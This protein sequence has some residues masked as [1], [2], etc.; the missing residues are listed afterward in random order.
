MAF[1]SSYMLSYL[2]K[3]LTGNT[4]GSVPLS[5]LQFLSAYIFL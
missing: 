3:L 1:Q 5:A 2:Q 4:E